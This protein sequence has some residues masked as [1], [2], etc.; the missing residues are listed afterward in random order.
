[1]SCFDFENRNYYL[2]K[3]EYSDNKKYQIVVDNS[4]R[5]K[6]RKIQMNKRKISLKISS[7]PKKKNIIIN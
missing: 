4:I 7:T 6:R 5:G 1:M 2:L 3:N